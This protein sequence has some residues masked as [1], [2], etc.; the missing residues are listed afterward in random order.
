MNAPRETGAA[1]DNPAFEQIGRPLLRKEDRRLLTGTARY[2]DDIEV[3]GALHACF[4]RS[5]YAHARIRGIDAGAAA[6]MPGVVAV[7]TGVDLAGVTL[8]LRMA[9]PIEGL[10]PTEVET[11]PTRKVRFQGDPVACVVATDRYLAEDA[12][13]AVLVDYEPLP[14]VASADAALAEGAPLVDE[15]LPSNLVSRQTFSSG[16]PE[17]REREAARV[18][19]ATFGQHRQTHVP[20]E[21]RGCI[22]VWDAGQEHLTLHVGTQVPHPYR[23]QLAARLRLLEHQ[24]TVV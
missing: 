24:V 7:V 4:V 18:V 3:P 12:A 6:T 17:K 9:P 19:E 21:T 16:D 15:T 10:L 1:L 5:P 2:V 11:L 22:A 13:E 14:A 23:S 20:I 8:P